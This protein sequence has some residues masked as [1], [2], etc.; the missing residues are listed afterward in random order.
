MPLEEEKT[1]SPDDTVLRQ[2]R[3]EK[4]MQSREDRLAKILSMASGRSIDPAQVH[5]D[6]TPSPTI[7]ETAAAGVGT[8]SELEGHS[9]PSEGNTTHSN[10]GNNISTASLASG[11][12]SMRGLSRGAAHGVVVVLGAIGF[13]VWLK[14][15]G[16]YNQSMINLFID[17]NIKHNTFQPWHILTTVFLGLEAIEMIKARTQPLQI[18]QDVV[19]YLFVIILLY[20]LLF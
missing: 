5:L 19:L 9:S 16:L 6:R 3:K 17:N 14:L 12:L 18:L 2:R 20:Q 10:R 15:T 7:S 1:T 13:C 8:L 11:M 4:I